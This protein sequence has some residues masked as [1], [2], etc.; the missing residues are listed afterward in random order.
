M[1]KEKL[2]EFLEE[3]FQ[4]L[5]NSSYK[6]WTVHDW[7]YYGMS[8][9]LYVTYSEKNAFALRQMMDSGYS[10]A[11]K[12]LET[13]PNRIFEIVRCLCPTRKDFKFDRK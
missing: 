9:G 12:V 4:S 7:T 5:H 10:M 1:E 3:T 8:E 2:I 11:G 6:Y 13:E